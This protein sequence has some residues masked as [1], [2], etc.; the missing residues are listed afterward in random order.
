[1]SA[2]QQAALRPGRR[3]V[4]VARSAVK[5]AKPWPTCSAP[6]AHNVVS[7][8]MRRTSR[9]PQVARLQPASPCSP[10]TSPAWARK[11]SLAAWTMRG[12]A[13]APAYA[14]MID[15]HQQDEVQFGRHLS[16]T[17]SLRLRGWMPDMLRPLSG[18]HAAALVPNA[19]LPSQPRFP[20]ARPLSTC[21]GVCRSRLGSGFAPAKR[22]KC[23][24]PCAAVAAVPRLAAPPVMPRF[25]SGSVY[26]R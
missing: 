24:A 22:A 16:G 19:S 14:L 18:A 4:E 12:R 6:V 15:P 3:R 9:V 5:R 23:E 2:H 8:A 7:S 11:R 17:A 26:W 1:M 13:S 10:I 20:S 25:T 21:V